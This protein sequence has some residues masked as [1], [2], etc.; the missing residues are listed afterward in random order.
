MS[1]ECFLDT[2]VLV[3]AVTSCPDEA[4]KKARALEL[5]E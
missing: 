1:V 3:Y 5:I 2:S 4:A